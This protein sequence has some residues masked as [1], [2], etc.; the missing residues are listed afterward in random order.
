MTSTQSNN[1]KPT[2]RPYVFYLKELSELGSD[3]VKL[4][5]IL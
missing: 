2:E 1:N 3:N 4:I 5:K